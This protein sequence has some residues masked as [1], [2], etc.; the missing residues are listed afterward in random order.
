MPALT[1]IS[2]TSQYLWNKS[3]PTGMAV[4]T[5]SPAFNPSPKTYN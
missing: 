5:E 1:Q 3:T 4:F 2:N